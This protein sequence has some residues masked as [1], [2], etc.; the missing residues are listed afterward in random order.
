MAARRTA[1]EGEATNARARDTAQGLCEQIESG[2]FP[3]HSR[4]PPER[5]L[6]QRL[7]VSRTRLRDALKILESENRIWRHVGKGTFVGGRPSSVHS[8]PEILGTQTTL[9]ELLEARLLIEPMAARLA[10]LRAHG[11][12]L[13]LLEKCHRSAASAPDWESFDKWDELFHRALAE[14][15]ANGFVISVIDSIFRA[16]RQSRWC[17]VRASSFNVG[18]RKAYCAHHSE[19]VD[20]VI[21]RDVQAA[22]A[23]MQRHIAAIS[24]SLGPALS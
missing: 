15:S 6:S 20:A 10:A 4:L 9:P 7:G 16:K 24:R 1:C 19:I 18:L 22:E 3:L 11:S 17:I 21:R 2:E 14:A 5:A 8:R 12:D 13:D 23:A